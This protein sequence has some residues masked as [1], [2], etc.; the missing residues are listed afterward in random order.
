MIF[1]DLTLNSL[2]SNKP[3]TNLL[4]VFVAIEGPSIPDGTMIPR[5]LEAGLSKQGSLYISSRWLTRLH[6]RRKRFPSLDI[7][8][9]L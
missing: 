5:Q 1:Q 7:T 9:P 3:N 6:A 8:F 2:N 4:L